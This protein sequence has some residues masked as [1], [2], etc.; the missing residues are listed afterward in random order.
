MFE[1]NLCFLIIGFGI[2]YQIINLDFAI[3]IFP[4]FTSFVNLL[5]C[6]YDLRVSLC[7]RYIEFATVI[8][9][10][11]FNTFSFINLWFIYSAFIYF[12]AILLGACKFRLLYLPGE[13]NLIYSDLHNP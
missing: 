5:M 4:Y 12:K 7:M 1:K 9:N 6:L 8:A 3:Q 11:S 2:L 13:L 10:L